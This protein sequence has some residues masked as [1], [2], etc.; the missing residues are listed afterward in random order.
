ML[1]NK[2]IIIVLLAVFAFCITSCATTPVCLTSSNTPLNYKYISEN[3]GKVEG[4]SPK[5]FSILSL[6]MIGKPDIQSAIDDAVSKKNADALI[7]IKC[8]EVSYNFILFN[9]TSVRVEGE[10]VKFVRYG[11]ND[12]SSNSK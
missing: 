12:G 3:M 10:A 6:W 2:K 5:T 11:E 4:N 9:L 1:K 8:Y 7:N